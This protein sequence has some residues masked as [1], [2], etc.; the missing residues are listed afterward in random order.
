[1][2]LDPFSPTYSRDPAA[3]WRR[4]YASGQLVGYD[5]D[6]GLWLIA[7]HDNV[8]TALSDTG[9]FSN[10]TTMAPIAAVSN[11]AGAVLAGLDAPPVAVTADPPAHLRTRAI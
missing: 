9:R 11:P 7:G 8:R 1:M 4:L 6:L 2:R 5:A 10:A 3:T